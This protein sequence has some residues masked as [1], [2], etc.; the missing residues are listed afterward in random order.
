MPTK[1]A[2]ELF[3][4]SKSPPNMPSPPPDLAAM[5]ARNAAPDPDWLSGGISRAVASKRLGI[6]NAK[7]A[8]AAEPKKIAR[9]R[10]HRRPQRILSRDTSHSPEAG[11][12]V[13]RLTSSQNR[14]PRMR[15][16]SHMV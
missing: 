2:P 13:S 8:A 5:E 4:P 11:S 3:R 14:A 10:K 16:L 15:A 9:T 1:S 7:S 6:E 12:S